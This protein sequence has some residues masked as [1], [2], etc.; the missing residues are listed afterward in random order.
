[1]PRASP[2]QAL[3]DGA[4]A[5][6]RQGRRRRSHF[7]PPAPPAPP[8]PA[9]VVGPTV[10]LVAEAPPE[11]PAPP[12]P[13]PPAVT[14]VIIPE[15]VVEPLHSIFSM[16]SLHEH[17]SKSGTHSPLSTQCFVQESSLVQFAQ[18]QLSP[19]VHA[20]SASLQLP[21][22]GLHAAALK[23]QSL[24]VQ[25]SPSIRRHWPSSMQL[26]WHR[27][28]WAQSAQAQDSGSFA[29]AAQNPSG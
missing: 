29:Y 23:K 12:A 15:V 25:S 7:E 14:V 9:E 16:Q 6:A 20:L 8:A 27:E 13:P 5:Q 10:E 3:I 21:G 19:A 17:P 4:R 1:M 26:F 28:D 11:P 2:A 24:Q 22:F 18:R